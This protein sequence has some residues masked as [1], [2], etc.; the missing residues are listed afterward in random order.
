MFKIF[1]KWAMNEKMLESGGNTFGQF[2]HDGG[3]LANHHKYQAFAFQFI[4]PD[5]EKNMVVCWGFPRSKSGKDMDV[6][7]LAKD[8]LMT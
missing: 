5:W 1:F 3:T 4:G 2:L 6:A 8:T 7:Q